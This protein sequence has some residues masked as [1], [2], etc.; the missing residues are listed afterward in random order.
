VKPIRTPRPFHLHAGHGDMVITPGV[1]SL[2]LNALPPGTASAIATAAQSLPT[3]AP[4]AFNLQRLGSPR[5]LLD[6]GRGSA[7][8]SA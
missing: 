2:N 1:G 7:P 4:A 8:E 5:V 6:S 3:A